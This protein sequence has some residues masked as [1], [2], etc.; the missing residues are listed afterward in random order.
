M[1][2]SFKLI[3]VDFN[4]ELCNEWRKVFEY[5]DNVEVQ[6]GIF[7]HLEF[8]CVVSPANSFGQMD[9]GFDD[10]LRLYFG[11]QMVDRV[12]SKVIEYYGGEQP[13]GTSKLVMAYE[14]ENQN[15]ERWK[16]VAHTP[17]M[18]IPMNISKTNNVY[19]AMK[20]MLCEIENHNRK[21]SSVKSNVAP[22]DVPEYEKYNETVS[23]RTV[24]CP[25]LGTGAGRVPFDRAAQEMYRAYI[26]TYNRP[27][28]LD[29]QFAI[30]RHNEH[31]KAI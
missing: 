19:S 3:L 29:W 28:Q 11:Q 17:T 4:E 26:D 30:K 5:E 24:V 21:Y 2:P 23:I 27:E 12:Q 22:I 14:P 18:I 7:E 31:V 10:A 1:K 9:G 6:N 15:G 13:V 16:W 20:A 8:D 25:G